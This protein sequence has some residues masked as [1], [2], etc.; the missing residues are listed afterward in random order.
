[1]TSIASALPHEVQN[2]LST[3]QVTEQLGASTL[4]LRRTCIDLDRRRQQLVEAQAALRR[5]Q[6]QFEAREQQLKAKLAATRGAK[7]NI[8]SS[9]TIHLAPNVSSLFLDSFFLEL[10]NSA[11]TQ[12]IAKDSAAIT[13]QIDQTQSK[14][15]SNLLELHQLGVKSEEIDDRMIEFA[16]AH[17]DKENT[18][19]Q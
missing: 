18:S 15:K 13:Q 17:N 8:S 11:I 9:T 19:M 10:P 7:P 6:R 2:L 5:Q 12:I 3:S 16:F 14:I 4:Q 1:M